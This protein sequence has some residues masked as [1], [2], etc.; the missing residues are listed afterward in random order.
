[1]DDAFRRGQEDGHARH[2]RAQDPIRGDARPGLRRGGHGDRVAKRYGLEKSSSPR[3]G[4]VTGIVVKMTPEFKREMRS[5]CR[6]ICIIPNA[7][8][9]LFLG[10]VA[11]ELRIPFND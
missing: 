10:Q 6:E 9:H 5:Y 3:T 7:L 11:F 2:T 4:V 8:A 1:M